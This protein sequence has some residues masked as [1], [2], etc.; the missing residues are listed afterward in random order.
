MLGIVG[1]RGAHADRVWLPVVNL[2]CVPPS[3]RN[4]D[5]VFVEPLAAACEILAQVLTAAGPRELVL[6]G[7][8]RRKPGLAERWGIAT[9]FS[10]RRLPQK[11][12]DLVVEATGSAQ[13]LAA[14]VGLLRPRGTLVLKSTVHDRVRI[15][16][17]PIVVDEL[18]VVG[19]RCGPFDRA[20]KLLAQSKV[21]SAI[22]SMR[23]C[24]F[25]RGWRLSKKQAAVA[26]SKC[27]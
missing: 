13:G 12:F 21:G 19:S 14:A 4:E 18:T 20:L 11:E 2:H 15:D 22:W 8:H 7:K 1:Q 10:K 9:R 16:T 23:P 6:I 17:A 27:G 25:R 26:C 24:P 3:V 5:A